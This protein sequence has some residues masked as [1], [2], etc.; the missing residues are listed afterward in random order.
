MA[1]EVALSGGGAAAVAALEDKVKECG[2]LLL[3]MGGDLMEEG[4]RRQAI[5]APDLAVYP[6]ARLAT[7][8]TRPRPVHDPLRV[9]GGAGAAA[10]PLVGG[11]GVAPRRP[12][13]ARHGRSPPPDLFAMSQAAPSGSP[14]ALSRPA[15]CEAPAQQWVHPLPEASVAEALSGGGSLAASEPPSRPAG[16]AATWS[17]ATS[18]A[19][20][21]ALGRFARPGQGGH[22]ALSASASYAQL[23]ARGIAPPLTRDSSLSA[24]SPSSCELLPSAAPTAAAALRM[25][26]EQLDARVQQILGKHGALAAASRATASAA[27]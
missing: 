12:L 18:S 10:A 24:A 5:E 17:A 16:A 1:R 2:R 14:P 22:E 13:A 6:A 25:T 26:R 7:P 27:L 9:G 21:S 19:V 11:G 15:A 8:G 23:V 20:D 4:R 3:R